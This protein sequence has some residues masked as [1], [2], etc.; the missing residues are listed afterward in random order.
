MSAVSEEVQRQRL[1][2]RAAEESRDALKREL[3]GEDP[4]LMPDATMPGG[5]MPLTE[6]DTRIADQKKLLDEL[7]RRYTDQHPDVISTKRLIA[8]LEEQ[9]KQELDAR[10]KAAAANPSKFTPSTNPVFQ[11]IKISLADAEANV[12]ALRARVGE[13]EA[14]MAQLKA[15]PAGRLRSR[16][17]WR[18]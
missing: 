11:K 15:A 17:R 13:S 10:R 8:Q 5:G 1:E 2:L 9:K 18:S 4:V 7:M 3:V 16:P 6:F 12:A 14:R